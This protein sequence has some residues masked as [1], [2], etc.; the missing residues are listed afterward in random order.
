MREEDISDRYSGESLEGCSSDAKQEMS[1]N[2]FCWRV[3][4][5]EPN[6]GDDR[7]Q[8]TQ[9]VDASAA[10]FYRSCQ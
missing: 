4:V 7:Q 8:K 10:K 3:G 9:K 2:I 5:D 6:V 1:S